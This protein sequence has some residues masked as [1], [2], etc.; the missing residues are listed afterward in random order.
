M[1]GKVQLRMNPITFSASTD[2]RPISDIR[3]V[4]LQ[5]ADGSTQEF[6]LHPSKAI[7][8]D[9]KLPPSTLRASKS[10][11]RVVDALATTVVDAFRR[12]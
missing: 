7:I 10:S 11:G 2:T 3:I 4:V 6:R 5:D 1:I 8:G 12:V 9:A